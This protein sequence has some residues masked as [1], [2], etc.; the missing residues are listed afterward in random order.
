MTTETDEIAAKS[1]KTLTL[2]RDLL[3]E[4]IDSNED[5]DLYMIASRMP[6]GILIE[7]SPK[8]INQAVHGLDEHTVMS[9]LNNLSAL[10]PLAPGLNVAVPLGEIPHLV[11]NLNIIFHDALFNASKAMKAPEAAPVVSSPT[12]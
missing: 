1:L 10:L 8:V 12:E 7:T 9:D 2:L 5:L 3:T 11:A 4:K 6:K